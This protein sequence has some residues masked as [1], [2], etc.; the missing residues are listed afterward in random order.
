MTLLPSY[1][2]GDMGSSNSK[3]TDNVYCKLCKRTL[4]AIIAAVET[5]TRKN[6]NANPPQKTK[7]KFR[8]CKSCI[9]CYRTSAHALSQKNIFLVPLP[10]QGESCTARQA[11][12]MLCP[13]KHEV[14]I[15]NYFYFEG[16]L[17]ATYCGHCLRKL[18]ELVPYP[19]KRVA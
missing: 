9:H 6:Y 8:A 10:A 5:R 7:F 15:R 13:V 4:K 14:Y 18:A 17:L 3:L 19:E 2:G 11:K 12:C 16:L 1:W